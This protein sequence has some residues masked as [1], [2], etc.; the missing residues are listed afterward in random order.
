MALPT[1][2]N[3]NSDVTVGGGTPYLSSGGNV[4]V[5]TR[6][7]SSRSNFQIWKA[8]DP[9][10][11]FSQIGSDT[12]VTSTN[13]I[14]GI[15]TI[16]DGQNIHIVTA[17]AVATNGALDLRYHVFSMS[18]DSLTTTNEL[19]KD[20]A[21]TA[22]DIVAP[23][24]L[25]ISIRSDGDVIVLY[26][27][28]SVANMGAQRERVY[29]ARR[30]GTWTVDVAVDNGGATHWYAGG[31]VRGSS[32]RMHFFFQDSGAGDM[33]QRTLTSANSLEIFPA[34]FDTTSDAGIAPQIQIGISYDSS[35]TQKVRRPYSNDTATQ[36][37]S[38]KCDSADTPTMSTDV[39]I[40]GATNWKQTSAF[41]SSF[42][43]NGTTLWNTFLDNNDDIYTQSNANDGG[44][45]TPESFYTGIVT[46]IHTNIYTRGSDVVLAM[47]FDET[48][49]KYHEKVLV[50]GDTSLFTCDFECDFGARGR[51]R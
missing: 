21:V 46:N 1:T 7:T 38:A 16:Q 14:I 35:G 3:A 44:W 15:A 33:Y 45:T 11:S 12:Q 28:S 6:N 13:V 36:L 32:D 26:N 2:I 43:A 4:Y 27:G 40:T 17:D 20:N 23:F 24:P 34:S 49:P 18:S 39:D 37:N 9:T 50:A 47:V 10:S 8:T 51:R 19:I 48:D 22:N 25:G 30:E 31:I 5:V 41:Q 29:Y 42:T